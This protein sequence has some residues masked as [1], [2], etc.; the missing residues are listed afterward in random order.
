[1]K[2]NKF[3]RTTGIILIVLAL[4]VLIGP[5]LIPVPPLENTVPVEQLVDADSKFIE[6]NG[7]NVH[8]KTYGQGEPTFILLQFVSKPKRLFGRDDAVIVASNDQGRHGNFSQPL[9]KSAFFTG[10]CQLP[11]RLIPILDLKR[12]LIAIE[13]ILRDLRWVVPGGLD[14]FNSLRLKLTSDERTDV[15]HLRG[16]QN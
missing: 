5:F 3:L 14:K 9:N 1:M 16:F 12:L 11:E 6:V 10:D 8:Y 15:I 4:I 13:N 7:I 2:S